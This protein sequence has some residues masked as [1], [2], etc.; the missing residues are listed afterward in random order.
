MV[1]LLA[2]GDGA[3][4]SHRTAAVAWGILGGDGI[5]PVDVIAKTD[6]GR[7]LAGVSPRRMALH[8]EDVVRR[9]RMFVT[10]PVV[11]TPARTRATAS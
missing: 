11:T 8:R 5:R 9:Y 10:T 2:C 3:V 4:L 1:A 7:K 6:A